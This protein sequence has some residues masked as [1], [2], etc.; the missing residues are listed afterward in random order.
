MIGG[1]HLFQN[2]ADQLAWTGRQLRAAGVA[3]L[4]GVHCTGS[5]AVLRLRGALGLTTATAAVGVVGASFIGSH[6]TRTGQVRDPAY[7]RRSATPLRSRPA[8][9]CPSVSTA[10]SRR[11]CT[12][13]AGAAAVHFRLC[14][15]CGES[16][17]R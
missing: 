1:L 2:T 11:A 14:R 5:E 9:S 17:A 3:H 12:S 8:R 6:D 10:A 7:R 15:A 13:A 16:M 4:L